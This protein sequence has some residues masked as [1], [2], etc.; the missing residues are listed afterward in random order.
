M[1][2]SV[3]LIGQWVGSVAC[4]REGTIRPCPLDHTSETKTTHIFALQ[5]LNGIH[6]SSTFAADATL[7]RSCVVAME[8]ADLSSQVRP[9]ECILVSIHES[10]PHYKKTHDGD[11]VLS[12][13]T[14]AVPQGRYH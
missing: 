9:R 2:R 10:N 11:A 7:A 3:A 13:T 14:S 6:Y 12:P 5:N 1:N 4:V 8:Y